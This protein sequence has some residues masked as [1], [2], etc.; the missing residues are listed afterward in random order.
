MNELNGGK[1]MHDKI[2]KIGRGSL[3]Q[4][5]KFNDRIYL[6][7]LVPLD[8]PEILDEIRQIAR[9]NQYKKVFTKVPSW[10]APKFL[11]DGYIMEGY[12]P[13]FYQRREAAFFLSKFLDSDRLM[14]IE[15]DCLTEFGRLL[16]SRYE[17]SAKPVK[18]KSAD[19]KFKIK[20]LDESHIEQITDI[21]REV[22]LSYP[23]PIHNPDYILSTMKDHVQYYGAEK[24]GKLI[25][26]ASAE[27]DPK[28]LNAE[29][30]D[31]ATLSDYRGKNLATKLLI[32]MEKDAKTQDMGT[33]YTIARLNS[34]AMNKTF[35]KQGYTYAG[36][37]IN[38]TN[39]A[40]DIESMN[41]LYKHV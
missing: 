32:E 29:M 22:F 2:E 24:K 28:G 7:K 17:K 14:G 6:M 30:T 40:G 20:K 13:D 21:Y 9:E 12:V 11:S 1:T 15:H 10:A 3:I 33:L 5:G 35:L 25:A 4:H 31:F 19:H 16:T 18:S 34:L 8:Y 41:I 37:L 26:L 39:I 27:I 38:N 36:T 23:F